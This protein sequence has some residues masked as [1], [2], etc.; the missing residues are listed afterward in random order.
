MAL[1]SLRELRGFRTLLQIL[2]FTFNVVVAEVIGGILGGRFTVLCSMYFWRGV[3]F[4]F[5]ILARPFRTE[6]HVG[7]LRY[8]GPTVRTIV[9]GWWA[10]VRE[11]PAL[12]FTLFVQKLR[13]RVRQ[14]RGQRR[15]KK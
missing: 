3:S 15:S 12:S 9:R 8:I 6:G 11:V 5:E 4:L 10:Y 13:G 14:Q 7:V 2:L 1:F